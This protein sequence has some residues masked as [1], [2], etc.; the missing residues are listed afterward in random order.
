MSAKESAA[1]TV[2]GPD[3]VIHLIHSDAAGLAILVDILKRTEQLEKE[4]AEL[5]HDLGRSMR[6]HNADLNPAP[7]IQGCKHE[8]PG[9]GPMPAKWNCKCGYLMYRSYE[10]YCDD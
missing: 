3:G 5:R 9:P 7:Q 4:N 2:K 1:I 10:D 8:W 6:N